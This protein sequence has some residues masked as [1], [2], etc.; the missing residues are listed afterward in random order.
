MHQVTI[1]SG[2]IMPVDLPS[3]IDRDEDVV[4]WDHI[5]KLEAAIRVALVATQKIDGSRLPERG[6]Y[7]HDHGAI[8]RFPSDECVAGNGGA[9]A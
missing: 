7:K 3:S 5:L 9:A 4:P 8:D 6:R 2:R 1:Q